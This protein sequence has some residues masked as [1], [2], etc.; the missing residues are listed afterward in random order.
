M[1]RREQFNVNRLTVSTLNGC[2]PFSNA[3]VGNQYFIGR[4]TATSQYSTWSKRYNGVIYDDGTPMLYGDAA[5]GVQIQAAI[6]ASTGSFNNYFFVAPGTYTTAVGISAAGKSGIHLCALNGG[7]MDVGATTSVYLI[8]SGNYPVLTLSANTEVVGFAI[9]NKVGF[10]AITVPANIF[11]TDIH[12]NYFMMVFGSAVNI[13]DCTA[14]VANKMGRVHHN[15]FYTEVTGNATA[16]IN[17]CSGYAQDACYNTITCS[18]SGTLDYGIFNDSTGGDT[19]YNT[20][21]E[22]AMTITCGIGVNALAG[23]VVGNNCAVVTGHALGGGTD[24]RTFVNN[25]DG[26]NGGAAAIET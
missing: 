4:T 9:K 22:G 16:A 2:S 5:D 10:P 13:V 18:G 8:C 25:F 24:E 23:S 21:G 7:N 1:A 12:N 3:S 26:V 15:R 14:S 20:I 6:T 11:S 17:M 19:S